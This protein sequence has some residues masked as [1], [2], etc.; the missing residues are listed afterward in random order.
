M[1]RSLLIV[2]CD[3]LL[4]SVIGLVRFD[5]REIEVSQTP[6][7]MQAPAATVATDLVDTMKLSLEQERL[8]RE[9]ERLE[10]ELLAARL[11]QEQENREKVT[12]ALQ[13]TEQA[14]LSQQ[15]LTAEREA[16]IRAAREDLRRKEE[17]ARRIEQDRAKLATQFAETQTNLQ[18]IQQQLQTTEE[19]AKASQ[20]RLAAVESEFSEAQQ[21]LTKVQ[22]ELSSTSAEALAARARFAQAQA[23]LDA[24]RKEAEENRNRMAEVEAARR[25]AA[26]ERERIAGELKVAE[27]ARLM[28]QQQL[29]A[30]SNTIHVVQQEKQQIQAVATELAEGVV[31]FA[32]KQGELA[33]EIREYRPMSPH[34]IFSQF[35]TNRV[36]AD[37]RG[38]RPGLFGRTVSAQQQAKTILVTD[39]KQSYAIFHVEDT[40]LRL[41]STGTEWDRLV[42]QLIRKFGAV[43]LQELQF[44]AVDPRI[45]VAPVSAAD[46]AK[47]EAKPYKLVTDPYR[48]QEAMLIGAD[49]GYYGEGHFRIDP[50]YPSYIRMD[51]STF[52]RLVGKFN[53]SRG[54]LVFSKSGDLLGVMV[55]KQ[56][57]VLLASLEPA[58]I[59]ETGT[60]LRTAQTL[61]RMHS[62]ISQLPESLW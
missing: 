7:R 4:L 2:I 24:R 56:Y 22:Q 52:G 17:E 53:P 8:A 25:Q 20:E 29:V 60:N 27:T 1:N 38:T 58:G 3:F 16:E 48:F 45:L 5:Q 33:E 30:A 41:E 15:Q 47:L 6:Q 36:E 49:E 19:Q 44:L 34:A 21:N 14:L 59:I 57:C 55:N 39:G 11:E 54:D 10:R 12:S 42:A 31:Q 62:Y 13:T 9:Q 50:D 51:R 61:S 23:E 26:V 43:S 32:E 37:F 18:Q 28:T 46:V 40:P 35:I